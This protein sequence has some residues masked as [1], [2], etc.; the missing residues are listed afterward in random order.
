MTHP[1]RTVWRRRD[2]AAV[3]ARPGRAHPGARRL[4]GA[5]VAATAATALVTTPLAAAAPVGHRVSSPAAAATAPLRTVNPRAGAA[6][7]VGVGD[8]SCNAP[9]SGVSGTRVRPRA[10][11]RSGLVGG[12]SSAGGALLS[13]LGEGAILFGEDNALGWLLSAAGG[14]QSGVTPEQLNAQFDTVNTKLDALSAQQYA[15]CTAILQALQQATTTTDK[16]A[17][18]NLV[19]PMSTQ[20]GY[21][22]TYQHDYD[23]VLTALSQNGGHVDQLS[24]TNRDAL[25]DMISGGTTGLPG[26][27]DQIDVLESNSQPG[28]KSMIPFYSQVLSDELGYNPYQTHV[29]PAAFVDAG[30]AQQDYYA[31][32]VA[33]AAY[34]YTNVEHLAFTAD[35]GF[36]HTSDPNAVVTVVNTAQA[37][38]QKWSTLFSDGLGGSWVGQGR[39]LGVGTIPADALV[40]YRVPSRPVMWT[41]HPVGVDGDPATPEPAYCASTAQFCYAN[42]YD[43]NEVVGQTLWAVADTRLVR[44]SS[45]PLPTLVTAA[46]HDAMSDWRIPTTLDWTILQSA[47][48][49]GLSTWAAARQLT[50][51]DAEQ[52]TSHIAGNDR[53]RTIIAP[54]LVNTGTAATPTLGLL[55]STEATISD[56]LS[57]PPRPFDVTG[58]QNDN[59]V[60]GR[61]FLVRDFQAT[62]PPAPFTATGSQRSRTGS[63]LSRSARSTVHP[64]AAAVAARSGSA[65]TAH[66]AGVT[67]QAALVDL[68]PVPHTTPSVC[69]VSNAYTVPA[70]VGSVTITATGAAGGPGIRGNT[71]TAPGGVGGV[72]TETVPVTAGDVLYYQIGG[73]GGQ[74]TGGIAGGGT[75]G[76][77]HSGRTTDGDYSGGGGGLSG[78]STTANCSQWLVV[79]GG[80]GGAGS[81]LS[82]SDFNSV[83]DGGDGG[84][85]CATTIA[86]C[87]TATAGNPGF[88]ANVQSQGGPGG[89]P[90]ANQGGTVGR[91]NKGNPYGTAGDSGANLAGGNGGSA[92][93]SAVGGGGGGGGGY[94]GGGGGGG[95]GWTATGG[96][97]GGGGSFAIAGG[98]STPVYGIS[99]PGSSGSVTIT[100]I[101]KPQV[102]IT[103]TADSTSPSWGQ[104]VTLTAVLPADATGTIG[105]YDDI[106]GGCDGS[107]G[108]GA[109]CQGE[110]VAPIRNGTATL[111]TT[112]AAL[113]IG[114]HRLHASAGSDDAHYLAND[115]TSVD[116]TVSPANPAMALTVRGTVLPAGQIPSSV[117]VALPAD[118]TGTVSFYDTGEQFCATSR[119]TTTTD[120]AHLLG[121]ATPTNGYATLVGLTTLPAGQQQLYAS[122]PGD[123]HYTAGTSNTVPV[124]IGGTGVTEPADVLTAAVT[125]RRVGPGPVTVTGTAVPGSTVILRAQPYGHRRSTVVGTQVAT[126]AGTYRFTEPITR[127]THFAVST[128]DGTTSP[129]VTA[130]VAARVTEVLISRRGTVTVTVR[131][132]PG[133]HGVQVTFYRVDA[134]H[135]FTRIRTQRI[136]AASGILTTRFTVHRA[137]ITIQARVAAGDGTTGGTSPAH[138]IRVRR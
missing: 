89:A 78:V 110:G 132:F 51:L 53:P 91:L 3:T 69:S 99:T 104:P 100:P 112:A 38:I 9:S 90:P 119:T 64:A 71:A 11:G 80:G 116:L 56:I 12:E 62:A 32:I 26:I 97:G 34:L 37:N 84:D 31:G 15:D 137:R 63:Q 93:D 121:T 4:A 50:P 128:V 20:I 82:P 98:A 106:N 1:H 101:T 73:V 29:F 133:V 75:G 35:G 102:P 55:T 13:L 2:L 77:T 130:K 67:R 96:G 70:G 22:V 7:R 95:A 120:C 58:P 76:S 94:F 123:V 28:A 47:A 23:N 14:G 127:T 65:R 19:T 59:D 54:V 24:S 117:V 52:V 16:D 57:A 83:L 92:S 39:N 111:P 115:S 126:T 46:G 87:T 81:G 36:T 135:T 48:S 138:T 8:P 66:P 125:A 122:T 40:D 86:S 105:F 42:L 103:L 17:Y 5:L 131:T 72:V 136:D 33:Q 118:L 41:E 113:G 45:A 44:P 124:T 74:R 25:R 43:S 88:S 18:T 21:L 10:A 49:G 114:A 85:G 30:Y 109:A 134:D 79:A 68:A 6:G 61:L 60:A 129:T 27:I 107:T 108:P